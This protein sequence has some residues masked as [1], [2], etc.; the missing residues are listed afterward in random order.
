MA[1]RLIVA[2]AIMAAAASGA[3]QEPAP[4]TMHFSARG[5]TISAATPS[6]RAFLGLLESSR[7]KKIGQAYPTR[8]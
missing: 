4:Q 7:R 3:A 2:A 5:G 8:P 1:K 6:S